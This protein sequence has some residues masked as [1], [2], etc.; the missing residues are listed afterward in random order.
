MATDF[1]DFQK[2]CVVIWNAELDSHDAFRA[3]EW[4]TA[5]DALEIWYEK[6]HATTFIEASLDETRFLQLETEWKR[7]TARHSVL[8]D[9]VLN[10][11]YQQIIAMGPVAIPFILRSLQAEI[12]HWFWAL[13]MLNRGVDIADGENTMR[14]AAAKWLSWGR[15]NDY[16]G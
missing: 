10:P 15:E 12:N 2:T 7:E 14:N 9:I 1:E 3:H 6:A 16:L 11:A 8:S 4:D 5:D 13:K